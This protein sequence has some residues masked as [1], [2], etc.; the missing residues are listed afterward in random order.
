MS[1]P[2]NKPA[3]AAEQTTDEKAAEI[4]TMSLPWFKKYAILIVPTVIFGVVSVDIINK[5]LHRDFIEKYLP[6]YVNFVR[7]NYGFENEDLK[8]INRKKFVEYAEGLG[9]DVVVTFHNRPEIR[10][11]KTS[12]SKSIESLQTLIRDKV[13][14]DSSGVAQ[15]AEMNI[16]A[17][18]HGN[19]DIADIYFE[20][21]PPLDLKA[22]LANNIHLFPTAEIPTHEIPTE[23]DHS[24]GMENEDDSGLERSL[25]DERPKYFDRSKQGT[26]YNDTV[27]H[28]LDGLRLYRETGS[29]YW[30]NVLQLEPTSGNTGQRAS[31]KKQN[32]RQ[33]AAALDRSR[34]VQRAHE[35]IERYERRIAELKSEMRNPNGVGREIDDIIGDIDQVKSEITN[36]RRKHLN[37]FYYF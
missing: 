28:T 26:Q 32:I 31:S 8:E 6:A 13:H 37:Y 10:F 35:T 14:E 27:V 17:G 12:G 9:V 19:A 22:V 21:S 3:E 18:Q 34:D 7:K 2:A 11:S 36:I 20:D 25:W 23:G 1:S 4:A 33:G 15:I 5:P 16:V 30:M 24:R 29:L